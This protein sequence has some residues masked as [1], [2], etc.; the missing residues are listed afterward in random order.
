MEPPSY[1][2][3]TLHPTGL[4]TPSTP[5]PTY[6]E[7]G[8]LKSHCSIFPCFF[9]NS[10]GGTENTPTMP[11]KFEKTSFVSLSP[12][13]NLSE[14]SMQDGY[15]WKFK[16]SMGDYRKQEWAERSFKELRLSKVKKRFCCF[17]V[18]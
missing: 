10:S 15:I 6:V 12:S 17:A 5:P 2:E 3:A 7:A 9:H 1:E 18:V 8:K 11:A 16:H 13:T 4:G 14:N